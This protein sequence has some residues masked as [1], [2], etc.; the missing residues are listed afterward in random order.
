MELALKRYECG[1]EVTHGKLYVN[2]DFQC[3]ILEDM[4]RQ[5]ENG[6]E[7]VYGQTCIPRGRYRVTLTYSNRFNRVLP[8]LN[9]VPQFSGIRIH[10]GN[11]IA[12]TEGCLLPGT[13]K[14]NLVLKS[15]DAFNALFS[16]LSVASNSGD[17]I[18]ITVE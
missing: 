1:A 10:P 9:D 5:L 8:L 3:D 18:W 16:R 7:K 17:E 13:R 4:D 2:G 14:D 12:D 6:G 11:S 15:R